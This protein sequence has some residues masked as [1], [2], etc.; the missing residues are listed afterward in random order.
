MNVRYQS[1][2]NQVRWGKQTNSISP[3]IPTATGEGW[4]GRRI[5]GTSAT[6]RLCT[7]GLICPTPPPLG[8]YFGPSQSWP[9]LS[10]HFFSPAGEFVQKLYFHL[11]FF[12][13]HSHC[14]P[15]VNRI[16]YIDFKNNPCWQSQ[17]PKDCNLQQVQTK[18]SYQ[19][20]I[21][22]LIRFSGNQL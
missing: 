20:K 18:V 14:I 15:R 9:T 21:S 17:V 6:A 5:S 12:V 22:I 7:D 13:Q 4:R 11:F 1:I 3:G 2:S 10:S 8:G 19:L 16:N